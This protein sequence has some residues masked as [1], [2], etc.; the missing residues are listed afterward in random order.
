MRISLLCTLF[1]PLL[2]LA[3][4]QSQLTGT[5]TDN[6]GAVVVGASVIGHNTDTGV[7]YKGAS[8]ENGVYLLPFLP[9]GRYDLAC[10]LAGF[11]KFVRSGLVLETGLAATVDVQLQVGQITESVVVQATSALIESE[12]SSIGTLI[13]RANVANMPVESRRSASLVKLMGNVVYREEAQGEAIPRF[14][15]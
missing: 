8:N 10:E 6:T 5:I 9:P 13:E 1:V 11:K 3:Q 2:S 12:S 15:M 7:Q 4:T 14:T